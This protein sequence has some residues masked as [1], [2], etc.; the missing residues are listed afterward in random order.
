MECVDENQVGE[1]LSYQYELEVGKAIRSKKLSDL[2]S[3]DD[4]KIVNEFEA[5]NAWR[6]QTLT[7]NTYMHAGTPRLKNRR[8]DYIFGT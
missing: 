2:A 4:D 7:R 6:L 8:C 3:S 1:V 5:T